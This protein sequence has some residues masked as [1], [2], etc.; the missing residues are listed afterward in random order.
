MVKNDKAQMDNQPNMKTVTFGDL[1]WIDVVQPTR[2]LAK[3]LVEKYS[4][5]PMDLEDALN[6]QR[7]VSKIED[8]S[9]YLFVIFQLSV[10]NKVTRVS[11]RKQWSAFIGAN[12]LLTLR[13]PEFKVAGELFREC[14]TKEEAREQYMSQ[15]SGYL[16]YQ[17]AD[18]AIDR[19][20]KILDKIQ[21]QMENIEDNVF[22]EDIEVA[23][24]LSIL[25]RDIINQREVMF[26]GRTLLAE[27]ENKLKR[28]SKV[29]LTLYFSD[30]M[31][32]MNKIC[33][34]LDEYTEVIDVFKD[35]D[36]LLSGYRA[37][38]A[39][40][41]L[42]VLSAIGLPFLVVAGIYIILPAALD[43]SSFQAFAISLAAIIVLIGIAMY[44]LRRRRLI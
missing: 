8:Y 36:Y 9:D 37:N 42:T 39:V 26:P 33:N 6:P 40:R 18:H 3:Y 24:D 2:E 12:F 30:L 44:V 21:S 11:S 34:T 7:Q 5:N 43:K 41:T 10:F 16:L 15:G 20:F 35:T 4:L 27:L 22:K 19:Y 13:P 28:F 14:E 1:T 23:A 29:D 32:H 31:D 38:R 25:R 17:L